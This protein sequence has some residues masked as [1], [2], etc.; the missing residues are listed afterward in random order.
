SAPTPAIDRSGPTHGRIVAAS[1]EGCV[2]MGPF[3]GRFCIAGLVSGLAC[4]F[5][6]ASAA[7]LPAGMFTPTPPVPQRNWTGGYHRVDARGS[8]GHQRGPLP[9]ATTRARLLSHSPRLSGAIGA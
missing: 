4:A 8:W 5:G 3:R 7:D 1:M 9:D 2:M 6:A